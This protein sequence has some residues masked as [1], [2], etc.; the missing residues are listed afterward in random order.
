MSEQ[1]SKRKIWNYSPGEPI[2]WNP[3][4]QWPINFVA[5]FN[6]MVKRWVSISRFLMFLILGFVIYEYL[7]PSHQTMQNLALDWVL[8]IFLRNTALLFLI[9]GALHLYLHS[10]K[11]QGNKFKFLKREMATNNKNF[12][13]ND[14]VYDNIFWSVAS[15]V[16]VWTGYEVLYLASVAKGLIATAPFTEHPVQFLVWILCFPLIRGIHFYCIHRLLHHPFLYKHVH[17]THH[18]NVNTGPWSGISMHPIENIIYQSSPL[19]HFIIPS[20]PVI[21]IIH[22]ILVALNPAF[23]HSGFE[24]IINKDKKLLDSADFHHQLHH[25]YFDCNYGNVDVPLDVWFGTDHDGSREAT[26][27]LRIKKQKPSL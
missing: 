6:W 9:A 2:Q 20:D 15:G 5:A 18:R 1:V 25:K 16:T 17:I 22:L 24:K 14:Q 3:L 21:V 8:L 11:A 26:E 13:F 27:K 10:F 7:T 12:K 19:I 4:F 23:T